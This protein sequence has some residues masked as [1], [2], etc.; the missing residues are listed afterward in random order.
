MGIYLPGTEILG[1][2]GLMWGWDSLLLRYPSLIFIYHMWVRDQPILHLCLS[3]PFGG[4]WFLLF[5]SCQTS[6]NSIYDSSEWW[7]YI[8]VVI[9]LWL[10]EEARHVCLYRHLDW[11]SP[12]GLIRAAWS[13]T[14]TCFVQGST[15]Y[16]GRVYSL[17]ARDTDF[18]VSV[19]E[20]D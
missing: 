6:F 15:R 1:W 4:M 3:S 2:G 5:C 8:L 11:T 10:F 16:L 9:L 20:I 17:H 13:L 14:Y 19:M 18:G 12:F 7:F